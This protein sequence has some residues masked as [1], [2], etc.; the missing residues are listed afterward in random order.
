MIPQGWLVHPESPGYMWNPQTREVAAIPAAA[1][2]VAQ[3]AAPVV[4]QQA[5]QLPSFV[6][7]QQHTRVPNAY[8]TG[9][10]DILWMEFPDLPRAIGSTVEMLIRMIPL[11]RDFGSDHFVPTARHKI[12]VEFFDYAAG[13]AKHVYLDC[14]DI[15]GGPGSCPVCATIKE[16]STIGSKEA[17]EFVQDG[18]QSKRIMVQAIDMQK[19]NAHYRPALQESGHPVLDAAGQP[20]WKIV[21][22][23]FTV[24]SKLFASLQGHYRKKAPDGQDWGDPC[25]PKTGWVVRCTKTRAG[26][27]LYEVAYAAEPVE[28]LDLVGS[29]YENVLFNTF[30]IKSKCVR[31]RDRAEIEA[32]MQRLLAKVR[33]ATTSYGLPGAAWVPHP[34]YPGYEY[35]PATQQ[36]R[37]MQAPTPAPAYA[38]APP[39]YPAAPA[40]APPAAPAYAPP[41]AA[42]APPPAAYAPAYAPPAAPA[43]PP[44][45][46]GMHAALPPPAA[47]GLVNGMPP[48]PPPAAYAPPV[49][50]PVGAFGPPVGQPPGAQSAPGMPAAYVP[51]PPSAALPPPG[52]PPPMPPPALPPGMPAMP[53]MPGMPPPPAAMAAPAAPGLSPEELEKQ[54]GK[55]GVPYE[56]LRASHAKWRLNLRRRAP[57]KSRQRSQCRRQRTT[58]VVC[59]MRATTM[60]SSRSSVTSSRSRHQ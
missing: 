14:F 50:P 27:G 59:A 20:T 40:Y 26:F 33:P 54:I 23:I 11:R 15:L 22:G 35:N 28:R 29:Q 31:F 56:W 19:M 6:A 13:T 58:C 16:L 34:N 3:M 25:D 9:G 46:A 7:G 51:P 17:A 10:S 2:P 36:V 48:V 47:P 52:M 49:P 5:Q 60:T 37:P 43:M 41:P 57:R 55:D 44:P 45:P 4:A 39:A 8:S 24:K 53:A 1:P 32:V 18:K 12:P 21:P 38:P 30:D 42:Y